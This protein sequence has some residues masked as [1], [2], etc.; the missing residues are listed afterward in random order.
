ME[1]LRAI[2][3]EFVEKLAKKQIDVQEALGMSK[4]LDSVMNTANTQ[5]KYAHLN[6]TKADIPFLNGA[7]GTRSQVIDVKPTTK[8]LANR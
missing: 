2:A 8:R 3:L 6:D 1:Q 4:L 5:M 7:S